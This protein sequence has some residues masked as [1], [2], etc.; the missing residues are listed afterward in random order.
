MSI[1]QENAEIDD[2]VV[3]HI[4]EDHVKCRLMSRVLCNK[5]ASDLHYCIRMSHDEHTCLKD[6]NNRD[7]MLRWICRHTRKDRIRMK[8]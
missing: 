6:E 2:D 8:L 3:H 4:K 1:I 5:N 7:G